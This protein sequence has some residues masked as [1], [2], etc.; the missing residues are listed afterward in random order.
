MKTISD[1]PTSTIE[2]QRKVSDIADWYKG[3]ASVEELRRLHMNVVV[4]VDHLNRII[5]VEA[6][7]NQHGA[8]TR[9]VPIEERMEFDRDVLDFIRKALQ[10][11]DVAVILDTSDAP[12]RM[13]YGSA[14]QRGRSA[15]IMVVD[16]DSGDVVDERTITKSRPEFPRELAAKLLAAPSGVGGNS[17]VQRTFVAETFV[18]TYLAPQA[19]TGDVRPTQSGPF[20]SVDQPAHAI[21]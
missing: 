20:A 3:D 14:A 13:G 21:G 2:R 10:N 8:L 15:R 9:R 1:L 18:S 11:R 6:H 16:I 5:R 17:I 4:V 19:S 7:D 12:G